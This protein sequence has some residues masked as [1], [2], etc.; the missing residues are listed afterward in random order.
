LRLA[1]FDSWAW[2]LCAV[3][4]AL[5]LALISFVRWYHPAVLLGA[6]LG[7]YVLCALAFAVLRLYPPWLPVSVVLVASYPV[8]CLTIAHHR[9]NEVRKVCEL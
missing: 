3:L 5:C 1:S 6:L 9:E 4:A 7:Y 2:V 8:F